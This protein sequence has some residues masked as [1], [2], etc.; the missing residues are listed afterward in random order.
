MVKSLYHYKAF[1]VSVYDGDTV[2]VDIDL[3]LHVTLKKEKIRLARINAPELRGEEHDEGIKSRDFLRSLV[4]EKN[5]FLETIKDRK[6][7]YGR[8]LGELWAQDED[9]KYFNVNDELVK[10]GFAVYKKY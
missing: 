2:T 1:V 7:K 4:I 3:G 8:Y 9:E 10:K 6:G 5:I